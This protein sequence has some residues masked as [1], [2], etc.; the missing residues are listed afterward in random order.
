M[1][2]DLQ[3]PLNLKILSGG[4]ISN[5]IS[6][7]FYFFLFERGE[8]GGVEDAFVYF[9]DIANVPVDAAVGQF[10]VSDAMFKREL[11]LEYQDYAISYNF[12]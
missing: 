3:T 4:P 12:V 9:N 11:R 5:K 8:I 6:Y 1:E 10:Q 2:T 7:Y